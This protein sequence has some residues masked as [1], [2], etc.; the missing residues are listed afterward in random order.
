MI[1]A[2]PPSWIIKSELIKIF[3]SIISHKEVKLS[4]TKLKCFNSISS[5]R[6]GFLH[7]VNVISISATFSKKKKQ[8]I[9]LNFKIKTS[10]KSWLI[11]V[12][13]NPQKGQALL[14]LL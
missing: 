7:E 9:H 12:W 11:S 10:I 4:L 8:S 6:I 5:E 2:L 3:D 13:H 1:E 14:A